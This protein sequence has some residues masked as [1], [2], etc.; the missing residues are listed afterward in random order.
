VIGATSSEF[1]GFLEISTLRSF[2]GYCQLINKP[3]IGDIRHAAGRIC[4]LAIFVPL[5]LGFRFVYLCLDTSFAPPQDGV[6]DFMLTPA[7][8]AEKLCGIKGGQLVTIQ[9]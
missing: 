7:P 2:G 9:T 8:L 6:R 1:V 4:G 3:T 5:N